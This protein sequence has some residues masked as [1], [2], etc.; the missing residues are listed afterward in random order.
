M[1]ILEYWAPKGVA[2]T[3]YYP[4]YDGEWSS[5]YVTSP[6][7]LDSEAS[8]DKAAFADCTNEWTEIGSSG[9]GYLDLTADEM[10]NDEVVVQTASTTEGV[11]FPR[12]MQTW[13]VRPISTSAQ[14]RRPVSLPLFQLPPPLA[15]MPQAKC[16]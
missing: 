16:W 14:R 15:L 9:V 13:S 5:Q 11:N 10:D 4:A 3:L 2:F 6:A 8:I 12:L 1:K 7:G